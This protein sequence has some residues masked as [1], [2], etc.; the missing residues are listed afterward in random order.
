M[1]DKELIRGIKEGEGSPTCFRELYES[2]CLP[3][4]KYVLSYVKSSD[5]AKEITHEAL[6]KLWLHRETLDENRSV[7]A[8]LF[9]TCKN[10]LIKELRRQ[11]KNPHID[12]WLSLAGDLSVESRISYDYDT[13]LDAL[14]I[15]VGELSPRQ[16]EIF[17]MSREDGLPAKEIADRLGINEQVVR[18]QLS[19]AMKKIRE[20]IIKYIP[21]LIIILRL[22]TFIPLFLTWK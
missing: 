11:V 2:Y 6:V 7:R 14:S 22:F 21:F 19:A 12:D 3:L 5:T 16:Q 9:T 17:R 10:S 8:Y 20:F 1:T 15:A 4:Y 18:N 13:Y